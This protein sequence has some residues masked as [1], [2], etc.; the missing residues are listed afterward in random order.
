MTA[1]AP[2]AAA[3]AEAVTLSVKD[4]YPFLAGPEVNL[5]VESTIIALLTFAAGWLFRD[6]RVTDE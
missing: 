5:A 3:V 6:G 4:D 2:V 1:V